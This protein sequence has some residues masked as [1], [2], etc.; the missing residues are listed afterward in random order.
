MRRA[1][2]GRVQSIGL[3]SW[4]AKDSLSNI[5][6]LH[7]VQ[8]QAAQPPAKEY[9]PAVNVD[10]LV[11]PINFS[12]GTGA[13]KLNRCMSKHNIYR[14]STFENFLFFPWLNDPPCASYGTGRLLLLFDPTY[15][16][17]AFP[18]AVKIM[19]IYHLKSD[20]MI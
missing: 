9:A 10:Q 16:F 1:D 5:S 4:T 19:R 18:V 15:C 2:P 20:F 13:Q 11:L 7:R 6:F 17:L 8:A 12:R 14:R 3:V